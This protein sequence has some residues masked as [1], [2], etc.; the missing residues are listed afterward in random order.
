MASRRTWV[1]V[2]VGVLG[3]GLVT[4]IAVAGAGVYFV[5]SHVQSQSS[6]HADAITAFEQ[7]TSTFRGQKPLFELDETDQPR[8][9][10]AL[11]DLPTAS[12]T[13]R[14]LMVLSW[15]SDAQR[16]VKL[17]L[18]LWVVRVGKHKMQF[19]RDH[20]HLDLDRLNAELNEIERI[21]P[22]LLMDVR[23]VDGTRVLVWTQ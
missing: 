4:V 20:R 13:S 23:D 3:T 8:A 17:A 5:R 1:W 9:T 6:T 7:I 19:A 10:R 22:A 14:D 15:D 18:P 2:V 11:A 21:G 12:T 16:L